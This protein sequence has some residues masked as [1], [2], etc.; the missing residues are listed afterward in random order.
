MDWLQVLKKAAQA[1][2]TV[3]LKVCQIVEIRGKYPFLVVPSDPFEV[4]CS[5]D[6]FYSS[7]L[8]SYFTF[9]V[10]SSTICLVVSCLVVQLHSIRMMFQLLMGT[11]PSSQ[12]PTRLAVLI[13][14]VRCC[15][16]PPMPFAYPSLPITFLLAP[17]HLM[18]LHQDLPQIYLL[19]MMVDLDLN[20]PS[21]QYET[22]NLCQ[23]YICCT[24]GITRFSMRTRQYDQ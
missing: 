19:A 3:V 20:N 17:R 13:L 11:H 15:Q 21:R 2:K 18:V 22:H 1:L 7:C 12:D 24:Q 9:L 14:Q 8:E 23:Q 5:K 6:S 16:I 4:P 10:V